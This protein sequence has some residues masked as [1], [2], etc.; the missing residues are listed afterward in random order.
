MPQITT[1]EQIS[2][3][4]KK[5]IYI[6]LHPRDSMK[7]ALTFFSEFSESF[8]A[9]SS[10]ALAFYII[11]L[12]VPALTIIALASTL[13][14]ID[15]AT[16]QDILER[17]LMPKYAK[18]LSKVLTNKTISL[19]TIMIL[20]FS[21]YA[22]SRG[23][24]AIYTMTKKLF[25][26]DELTKEGVFHYYLYT[27][28]I[29]IFILLSAISLI[30]VLA[31]GPIAR[32][33]H[34]FYGIMIFRAFLLFM[35]VTLFFTLL[36]RMIP[37]AHIFFREAFRGALV[38]TI[39]EYLLMSFLDFYLQRANFSNVYGPLASIVM[40]L[41][42]L[43]WSAKMFYF[44]MFV[45]HRLYM[46]RFLARNVE[47]EVEAINHRGQAYTHVFR[48]M[49]YLKNVLPGERVEIS[50][51]KES[52]SRIYAIVSKVL[53]ASPDRM[54]PACYQCDLCDRCQLQYMDY[55]ASLRLKRHEAQRSIM[56]YSSFAYGD[57]VV[58][59]L[60]PVHTLTHYKKYLKAPVSFD[61]EYYI[62]DHHK[63][64][65]SFMRSCVLNDGK[66]NTAIVMIEKILNNY[67]IKI[68]ETVM[69]KVIGEAII[70]FIDCGHH[71]IDPQLVIELKKTSINSLYQMHKRM[72]IMTYTCIYGDAHYPFF[73]QGKTYQISPLNYIYTNQE[74][75]GHLLDL[76]I[77]LLD[78][79][80]QILTIGCGFLLNMALSQEVI[81]LNEKEAMY[82][83]MK[84]YAQ[85]H[86]LTHKKFLYGRVDARIGIVIS[87]H[88]FASAVVNLID[89]PLSSALS[90]AF[91]TARIPHLYIITISPHELMVSLKGNDADRLQSTYHLED[92]YGLDSEPYTM[93]ALWVFKL[94]LKN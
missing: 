26:L 21:V 73:Y 30:I 41:F 54:T 88:H 4:L 74:T 50:I 94:T 13:F 36:Y 82:R 68:V 15:L 40:V 57:E 84:D 90:Q 3:D 70:V 64:S 9:Y 32:I 1:K 16:L 52:R 69:F 86:Q 12:S 43:D 48:K 49:C 8:P 25:P 63:Q 10:A 39:G 7:K 67:M 33:F 62:G 51:M 34:V 31:I 61:Q 18:M 46:K 22:V 58:H 24:G 47:V 53:Q 59:E 5:L 29:T 19:S 76:M 71:G 77:S 92:V 56:K 85:K 38:A 75:L 27:I 28:R 91:F 35:M 93:N 44:G 66:M 81:A 6:F 17:F 79:D 55:E 2:Q 78:E 65:C 83:D 72:G 23:I 60:L 20:A 80:D 87:R 42:I 89:K 14:H 45:T 37:R 11:I